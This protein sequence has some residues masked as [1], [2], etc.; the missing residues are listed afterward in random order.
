VAYLSPADRPGA[1]AVA[2]TLKLSK[3]SVQPIDANTKAIVCPPSQACPSTVVVIVGK[4]LAA[5]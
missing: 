1:L 3:A 5:Q 4:D 2:N